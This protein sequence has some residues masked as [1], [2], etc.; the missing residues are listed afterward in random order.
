MPS[1]NRPTLQARDAKIVAGIQKRLATVPSFVFDGVS[2]TPV[3]LAALFQSQIDSANAV[4][5]AK[6]AW[7]SAVQ[8]DRALAKKVSRRC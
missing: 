2:Y 7:L 8:A 5:S 1:I 6:G 3:S 4:A